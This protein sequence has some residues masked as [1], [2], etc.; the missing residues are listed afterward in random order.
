M[1]RSYQIKL[2]Q[3]SASASASAAPAL[4]AMRLALS[5][6]AYGAKREVVQV[7][8]SFRS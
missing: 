7:P 3:A 6:G 4:G 1:G 2:D 5:A 8:S